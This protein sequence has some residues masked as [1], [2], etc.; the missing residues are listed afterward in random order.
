MPPND[1]KIEVVDLAKSKSAPEKG[2][3]EEMKAEK[4]E[5]VARPSHNSPSKESS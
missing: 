5:E 3:K 2:A 1:A 4:I